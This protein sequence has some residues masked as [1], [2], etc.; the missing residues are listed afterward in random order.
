MYA[1]QGGARQALLNASPASPRDTQVKHGGQ[2]FFRVDALG[3]AGHT[4]RLGNT[5][6][7]AHQ[8]RVAGIGVDVTCKQTVDLD[9]VHA[10]IAQLA[11]VADAIAHVFYAHHNSE[12]M[13]TLHQF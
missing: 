2:L 5:D 6:I 7:G 12:G 4:Q 3:N 8:C 10:Q 13:G 9:V 11:N 1:G